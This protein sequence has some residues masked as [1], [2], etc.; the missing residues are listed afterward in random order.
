[1]VK[2]RE[3]LIG[4]SFGA[5]VVVG[6][7]DDY[8][9]ANG[10]HYDKWKCQC[11]CGNIIETRGSSLRG[12]HT[13]SCG[14]LQKRI[15]GKISSKVNKKYNDYE[16]QEDYVIMYT[17]KGEP[18]FI[19]IED[20][21]KVKDY[22]W[23]KNKDGYLRGW[24]NKK[25]MLLHRLIMNCPD[26]MVVDHINH[27][28]TDNRKNN[29]RILTHQQNMMNMKIH[30]NN[31]SGASGVKWNKLIGKWTADITINNERIY[32]G[33]FENF[34]DAIKA[35]KEAEQKY[36]GEYSYDNSQELVRK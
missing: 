23:C 35:R 4:Q 33:Y 32:L 15:A 3:D 2:V 26:N 25:R 19:D 27:D 34:D 22:C 5:L 6:R 21:W 11:E 9:S 1:M 14:C 13:K 7:A 28:I 31:T 30:K 12:G 17:T 20:F 8:I 24:I 29:L 10:T 36:F 16:I 18:F